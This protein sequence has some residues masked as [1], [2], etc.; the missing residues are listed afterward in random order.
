[1]AWKLGS[2]QKKKIKTQLITQQDY[3]CWICG[4]RRSART[5]T[6]DHVTP[7]RFDGP[8]KLSNYKLACADCNQ[9]R[10][11]AVERLLQKS[12]YRDKVLGL[13]SS[14]NYHIPL[15]EDGTIDTSD[16][17]RRRLS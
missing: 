16:L 15:N 13:L 3:R 12:Y 7:Q 5:F 1:M 4:V 14:A 9:R 11:R 2:S 17:V 10:G 6:I 8:N